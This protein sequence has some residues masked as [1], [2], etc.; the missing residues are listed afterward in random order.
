MSAAYLRLGIERQRRLEIT[1]RRL[2]LAHRG[3]QRAARVVRLSRSRRVEHGTRRVRPCP[4]AGIPNRARFWRAV[5]SGRVFRLEPRC[6]GQMIER[7][8]ADAEAPVFGRRHPGGAA[9][10]GLSR[11]VSRA[12]ASAASWLSTVAPNDFCTGR[13]RAARAPAWDCI[14]QAWAHVSTRTPRASRC[15]A[16]WAMAGDRL[17]R[18]YSSLRSRPRR[19]S[20]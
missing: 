14:A 2:C 11:S 5:V 8:V 10:E 3:E 6:R 9:A 15:A 19:L 13:S 4:F 12:A 16:K 20:E 17:V 18:C 7:G 1:A